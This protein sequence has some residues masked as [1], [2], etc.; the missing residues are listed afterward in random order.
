MFDNFV[1]RNIPRNIGGVSHL[2]YILNQEYPHIFQPFQRFRT[3][4][5]GDFAVSLWIY[6]VQTA[7]ELGW[8]LISHRERGF[9]R[10]SRKKNAF[11]G[12]FSRS[13]AQFSSPRG[14]EK[15]R[16]PIEGPKENMGGSG[17]IWYLGDGGL[18]PCLAAPFIYLFRARREESKKSF[19]SSESIV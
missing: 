6:D 19:S 12:H 15:G 8:W 5:S 3:A 7:E 4:C 14:C 10:K 17:R 13:K 2:S 1:I 16:Q 18:R 9:V 11:G